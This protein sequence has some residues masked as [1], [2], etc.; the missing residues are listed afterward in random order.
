MH[1]MES[2]DEEESQMLHRQE[3]DDE[4]RSTN[5]RPT[6]KAHGKEHKVLQSLQLTKIKK[7][8]PFS[9]TNKFSI[10]ILKHVYVQRQQSGCQLTSTHVNGHGHHKTSKCITDHEPSVER[11]EQAFRPCE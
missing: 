9:G 4:M 10:T 3:E 11:I 8:K 1:V 2:E 5:T 7:Q 6:E